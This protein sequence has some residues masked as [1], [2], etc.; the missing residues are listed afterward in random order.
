MRQ[1]Q[2]GC[3]SHKLPKP[4][5]NYDKEVDIRQRLP[6]NDETAQFI[7]AEHV[8]EHVPFRDGLNFISQCYRV[9]CPGGVLRLSF[10]DMTNIV[11][12]SQAKYYTEYVLKTT[13]RD[14]KTLEEVWLSIASDWGHCA[15]W[16]ADIAYRLLKAVRFREVTPMTYGWSDYPELH[17]VDGR[18]LSEGLELASIETTILEAVK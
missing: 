9:L 2:F 12:D 17:E 4:W 8:I 14:I 11:L 3:G 15:V 10:P 1:L 18:H 5:E 13:G 6:F 7:F 16:T